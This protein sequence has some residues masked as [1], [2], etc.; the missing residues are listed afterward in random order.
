MI[1]NNIRQR[2][3][4]HLLFS[5]LLL[6]VCIFTLS[7]CAQ[8]PKQAVELSATV[9]R[10]IAQVY[11][12][13]KEIAILL[14]DR[15]KKDVN[16]FVDNIYAPYQIKRQL[17]DD[18]DDFKSGSKDT[19]F[20]VLNHAVNHPDDSQAQLNTLVYM[21]IFLEVVR[22][23][24]ES[25]RQ[26]QL[27]FVI[28]QEQ[29]LLSAIDRSYNQIHYANSIVTGHLS[30]I[31]QVYDAQDQILR[32]FGI[33]GLRQDIGK[34]LAETSRKVSEYTDQAKKIDEN[35]DETEKKIKNWETNFHSLFKKEE[36]KS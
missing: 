35:L 19:L 6:S 31:T 14:Y 3:Y 29:K 17:K 10:D 13:H 11:Q 9:G 4:K 28:E 15:I 30:S 24:I 1:T 20:A 21:E 5:I 23:D 32:E 36:N 34:T 25:F 2:I 22:G 8:V 27:S 12:S 16:N 33:E 26:E 18:Y 7:A